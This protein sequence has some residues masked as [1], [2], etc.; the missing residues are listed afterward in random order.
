MFRIIAFENV[1]LRKKSLEADVYGQSIYKMATV[2][3][4]KMLLLD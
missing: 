1:Y 4:S 2:D 3:G